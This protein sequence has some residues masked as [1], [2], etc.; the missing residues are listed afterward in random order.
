MPR[1]SAALPFFA[2]AVQGLDNL[3]QGDSFSLVDVSLQKLF[4]NLR[5]GDSVSS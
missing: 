5:L 4:P 3:V 2:A 1:I